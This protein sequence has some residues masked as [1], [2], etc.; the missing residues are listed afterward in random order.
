MSDKERLK[1]M[2][3]EIKHEVD[4][5]DDSLKSQEPAPGVSY[6]EWIK[7]NQVEEKAE[8]LFKRA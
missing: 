1:Q 8:P 2:L 3:K 4:S 5:M 7:S 6:R